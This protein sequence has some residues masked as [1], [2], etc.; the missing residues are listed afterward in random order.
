[1]GAGAVVLGKLTVG[2]RARIGANAAVLGDVPEGATVT[3][4]PGRTRTN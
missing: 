1:M 3:G 4:V 2:R